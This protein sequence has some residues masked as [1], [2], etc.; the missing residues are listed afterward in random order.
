MDHRVYLHH[1][2]GIHAREM[3]I[4]QY[5][6]WYNSLIRYDDYTTPLGGRSSIFIP[7]HKFY[8]N[9]GYVSLL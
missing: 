7:S 9:S 6:L 2:K 4:I 5:A 3:D 8:S 1:E